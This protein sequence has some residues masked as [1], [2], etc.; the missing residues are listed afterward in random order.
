MNKSAP[1]TA[2][3]VDATL[4]GNCIPAGYQYTIVNISL[5]KRLLLCDMPAAE[6][7]K[8]L[9]NLDIEGN[10]RW[11][12]PDMIA[13]IEPMDDK[14]Y[15][16]ASEALKLA[17]GKFLDVFAERFDTFAVL[18]PSLVAALQIMPGFRSPRAAA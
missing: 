4:I 16:L 6:R 3:D 14:G 7:L 12:T 18:N 10:E 2:A 5:T 9:E 1:L 11:L 15:E 8:T 13:T 17:D